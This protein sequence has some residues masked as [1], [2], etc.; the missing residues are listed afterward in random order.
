MPNRPGF[1]QPPVVLVVDDDPTALQVMART[2]REAGY[3]VHTA[4]GG[5]AALALA[6]EVGKPPDLVV[7]DIRMEPMGGPELAE[8]LLARGLASLFLFVTGFGPAAD[9][10][11]E[12]GPLL[13][14]PFSPE[15]LLEMVA[16]VLG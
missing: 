1:P 16:R 7:T 2:L 5:P 9:Y 6:E 10:N 15:R 4:D 3:A 13:P 12:V 14:K 8:R 11:E